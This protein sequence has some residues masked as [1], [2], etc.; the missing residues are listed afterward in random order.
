MAISFSTVPWQWE[1]KNGRMRVS[2]LSSKVVRIELAGK[3]P[4]AA[5][6]PLAAELTAQLSGKIGQH[7][8][9]HL[10]DLDVYDSAVRTESTRVVQEHRPKGVAALHTYTRSATVALGVRIANVALGGFMEAHR[11]EGEF[12]AAQLRAV[13]GEARQ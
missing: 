13:S 5:A 11:D 6:P 8:F 2:R 3:L 10:G 7:L 9:W 1:A 12:E 4:A